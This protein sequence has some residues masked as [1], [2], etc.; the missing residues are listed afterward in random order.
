MSLYYYELLESNQKKERIIGGN[1]K[2]YPRQGQQAEK[3][4]GRSDVFL[5][6]G[7]RKEG[8]EG[9][10]LCI[11]VCRTYPV[12]YSTYA[13][14]SSRERRGRCTSTMIIR[15]VPIGQYRIRRRTYPAINT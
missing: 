13:V 3:R 15:T 1:R 7:T 6:Y 8:E 4:R 14:T 9:D 10:F 12:R 5:P 11:V 2:K